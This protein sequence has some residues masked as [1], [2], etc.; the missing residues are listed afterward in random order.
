MPSCDPCAA[1][2]RT[3]G[4]S[5]M[6]W[7]RV[8]SAPAVRAITV[9][10]LF[11]TAVLASLASSLSAIPIDPPDSGEDRWVDD[12]Y[13]PG[14][15][16]TPRNESAFVTGG[17]ESHGD[18]IVFGKFVGFDNQPISH[19]ARFEGLTW[20]AMQPGTSEHVLQAIQD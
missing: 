8:R 11:S 7:T 4:G 19:V 15:G 10:T 1:R 16:R 18:M 14:T 9:A 13:A 2:H 6:V 5:S 3:R 12:F 17:F 20:H